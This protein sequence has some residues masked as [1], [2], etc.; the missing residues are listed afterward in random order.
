MTT[1]S[2][3]RQ[4]E[5]DRFSVKLAEIDWRFC[6]VITAITGIGALMLYS[7][8]GGAWSPW[9]WKHLALYG[10]CFVLMIALATA[11]VR[12]WF[13]AAYPTYAVGLL[14]LLAVAVDPT[15]RG[16]VLAAPAAIGM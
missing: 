15:S 6:F 12:V 14:L 9:A 13:A 16:A 8:A 4:G 1:Y 5:R 10:V 11:D 7:I 2:I 3:T